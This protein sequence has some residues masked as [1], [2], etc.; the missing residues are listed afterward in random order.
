MFLPPRPRAPVSGAVL[1]L[2]STALTAQTLTV[3]TQAVPVQGGVQTM[4]LDAGPSAAGQSY[5]ILGSLA[6]TI[7]GVRVAGVLL[8][9]NPDPYFTLTATIPN[10]PLLPESFGTLQAGGRATARF[11]VPGLPALAGL[12]L[13]HAYVVLGSGL[14]AASNAAP[15]R[16]SQIAL[17]VDG[18]Q[19][20]TTV[21]GPF[22]DLRG[23]VGELITGTSGA[24]VTVNGIAATLDAGGARWSLRLPA[25]AGPF[26]LALEV[27]NAAGA[28]ER[29]SLALSVAAPL[30]A[31]NA[32]V[33]GSG[34]AFLA[35]GGAGFAVIDLATRTFETFNSPPGTGSV[36][37]VAFSDGFIFLMDGVT[38]G[39]L[40]VVDAADPGRVVSGPVSVPVAPFSGVS[41]RGGRVVVSGGTSRLTVRSVSAA[42]VL[43]TAVATTDLGI[44]Q[45][46]AI[47]IA[48]GQRAIVSVDFA[49]TVSGAGFGVTAIALNAPP[50]APT[51]LFSRGLAGAGFT[52]GTRGPANF[53]IVA[54]ELPGPT[55]TVAHGGGLAFLN[56]TTG[57]VSGSLA[58]GSLN[59]VAAA[60]ST[61]FAV[62]GNRLIEVDATGAPSV[63][64]EQSIAGVGTAFTGVAAD[65]DFVVIAANAGGALVLVR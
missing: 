5:L 30:A 58:V 11:V 43:S 17:G 7:P 15:V 64:D 32:A 33:D 6:G 21:L 2:L 4:T 16:I 23:D 38:P 39:N 36:D 13:D 12:Q 48:G 65:T 26:A 22:L 14:Q 60:G 41:A 45:P 56:D 46:D 19:A 18:L 57:A 9:L 8:P 54:A 25:P 55:F 59:H 47:V 31:N 61:V 49:G 63:V 28:F 34:R 40:T 1:L 52:S 29:A 35:R 10:S 44:G 42:G 3:D 51:T 37:D 24:T 27:R 62:G 53:P 50:S 20:G